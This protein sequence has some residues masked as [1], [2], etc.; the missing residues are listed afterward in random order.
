V[1]VAA[2]YPGT[3]STEILESLAR[4]PGVYAEW[5]PNEKVALEVAMG[6]SYGGVRA[7]AA[8]KHVGLNVAADPF[9]A[10]SVT[11]VRGGLVVV[12]ADDPGL[13][14]SQNEQD[15][16]HYARF[17]KVPL[18]EPS[19]SQEAY[20]LVKLAFQMSEDFDTPVLLRSTTRV[21]H[22]KS[23][24]EYDDETSIPPRKPGF[25][26]DFAK[27]VMIPAYARRRHPLMEERLVKLAAFTEEFPY[28]RIIWGERDY[29]IVSSGIAYHYAR[30]AFPQASFLKLTLSYPLPEKLVRQSA[31]QVGKLLVV[32]ELDPFLEEG[33]RAMGLPVSGK[34]LFPI[35]G[36]LDVEKVR[37]GGARIGLSSPSSPLPVSGIKELPARPPVLCPGCPHRG[38]YAVLKR[39]G[40][41]RRRDGAGEALPPGQLIATGDIGCYT[42]GV[43]PPLEALDTCACMGASIGQAMGLA[44]AGLPNPIVAVIGDSTFLHS[45]LTGLLDTA[46]NQGR[47]TVIILDNRTTAMTGHQHH[48][49][50]GVT[51]QGLRT[52][53]ADPASLAQAM[54]IE[55]V[56]VVGAFDL[57]ELEGALRE[58]LEHQ[59]PAVLV[60][61]SPCILLDRSYGEAL[62]VQEGSCVACGLC[63]ALGCP[64]LYRDAEGGV[65]ISPTLCVGVGCGLCL[66]ICPRE[67]IIV[68]GEG[69]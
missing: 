11:G 54:G 26:R 15:N 61:R 42:L 39:M 46:Y 2:A 14:S 28:N 47:L 22:A 17:A 35:V 66:Q 48:P 64:A 20:E 53:A 30:E 65:H 31:S 1:A 33:I 68:P 32:E 44:K 52:R 57:E 40:F 51:L 16:R 37:E 27:F 4:Y 62:S 13:H 67:A 3:P 18:L 55:M 49:G 43:L 25:R 5:S 58:C 19:D 63:L 10:A 56:R 34:A 50:T 12:S 38:L 59:G 41:F 69:E 7:M 23:A 8:M 29:G 36:E 6:A 24:V 45:G 60:V 9:F 21:S